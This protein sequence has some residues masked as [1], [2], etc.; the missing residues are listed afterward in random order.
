[1]A[2]AA[3]PLLPPWLLPAAAHFRSILHRLS[4]AAHVGLPVD[5]G[6]LKYLY[7]RLVRKKLGG[8]LDLTGIRAVRVENPDH[9]IRL[10]L[11][12]P[13]HEAPMAEERPDRRSCPAP[14]P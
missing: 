6:A 5:Y 11:A 1:M 14:R 3:G 8:N 9:R 12:L 4:A 13:A 2:S 10:V 7:V